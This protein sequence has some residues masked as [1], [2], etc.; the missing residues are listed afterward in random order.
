MNAETARR[1]STLLLRTAEALEQAADLAERQGR[2]RLESGFT[3]AAADES[4]A[5]EH[6]RHTAQRA[7]VYAEDL[8]GTSSGEQSYPQ[9]VPPS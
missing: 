8:S 9:A 7:R 3:E 1:I 5:A 4:R 2:R 6:A